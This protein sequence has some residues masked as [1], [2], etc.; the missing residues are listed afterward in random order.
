MQIKY[1][2]SIFIFTVAIFLFAKS[3]FALIIAEKGTYKIPAI[4]FK[5]KDKLVVGLNLGTNSECRIH[6]TGPKVSEFSKKMAPT[7]M[8]AVLVEFEWKKTQRCY[9]NKALLI[10]IGPIPKGVVPLMKVRNNFKPLTD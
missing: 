4:V 10:S 7:D 1:T 8:K 2:S 5:A 3:S 6:L 9:E